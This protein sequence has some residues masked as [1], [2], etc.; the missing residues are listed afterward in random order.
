V[1][2]C[3]CDVYVS[4]CPHIPFPVPPSSRL[5]FSTL[6]SSSLLFSPPC[7]LLCRYSS[8]SHMRWWRLCSRS[9]APRSASQASLALM[10]ESNATAHPSHTHPH[11]NATVFWHYLLPL[12]HLLTCAGGSSVADHMNRHLS[13]YS[14]TLMPEPFATAPPFSH[15]LVAKM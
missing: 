2:V 5:P 1:S 14:P 4:V 15:A 7:T 8:F 10:P 3:M 11:I 9:H 12:P 6:C 13:Q